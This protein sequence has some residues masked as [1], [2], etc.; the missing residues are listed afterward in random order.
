MNIKQNNKIDFYN[1]IGLRL[2]EFVDF[3]YASV[4][5][6]AKSVNTHQTIVS[7][8]FSNVF[9]SGQSLYHIHKQGLSIDW[10]FTGSGRMFADNEEGRILIDK[11]KVKLYG[12][13]NATKGSANDLNEFFKE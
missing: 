10:L 1:E 6:F 13:S 2:R 4:S 7:R 8:W 5:K 3:K 9:P 11:Y 12:R